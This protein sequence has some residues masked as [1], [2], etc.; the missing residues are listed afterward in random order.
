MIICRAKNLMQIDT[1]CF[2]CNEPRILSLA[3]IKEDHGV[4]HHHPKSIQAGHH[5]SKSLQPFA[6][7]VAILFWTP[8]AY[9]PHTFASQTNLSLMKCL[10]L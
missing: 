7:E 10:A 4:G 3:N 6:R 5:A 1:D 8:K 9:T 2:D